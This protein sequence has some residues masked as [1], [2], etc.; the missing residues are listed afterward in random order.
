M[1]S[2]SHLPILISL[3]VPVYNMQGLLERCMDGVLGQTWRH[4]EIILVDDGSTDGS[5]EMC[6]RYAQNDSRVRVIHRQNGGL[7][8]AK[9]TGLAAAQGEYIAFVDADDAVEADYVEVLFGLCSRYQVPLSACNHRI[10]YPRLRSVR[11]AESDGELVMEVREALENICYQKKPDVSSWAKLYEKR[12]FDGLSF[13][14]GKIYEDTA[15]FAQLMLRAGKIAFTGRPLY[16]YILRSDSL[17]HGKYTPSR[18]DYIEAVDGFC[19]T[20]CGRF[21]DLEHAALCRRVFA[22]LSVRRYLVKCEKEHRAE[23]ARLERF[24]RQNAWPVLK[25]KNVP[26]RDKIAVCALLA[27]PWAYDLLWTVYAGRRG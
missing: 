9:N 16:H 24:V 2:G 21:P 13:P 20:A 5:G 8:A 6:D 18:L 12:L 1:E 10:V 23:R 7:S 3:I 15:V 14:E 26:G 4:L 11:F 19:N 17:S 25:D 27:G 22:A